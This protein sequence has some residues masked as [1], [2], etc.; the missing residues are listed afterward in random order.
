[1][2]DP[3]ASGRVYIVTMKHSVSN[4]IVENR[5]NCQL[6][7]GGKSA[8]VE[9]I[10]IR[11]D[12]TM[13]FEEAKILSSILYDTTQLHCKAIEKIYKH[14]DNTNRNEEGLRINKVWHLAA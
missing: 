11:E 8:I 2:R 14:M 1:M 4:C 13:Q 7:Q 12:H 3:L 5:M 6:G 10:L 9:Y